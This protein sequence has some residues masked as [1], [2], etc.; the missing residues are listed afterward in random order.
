MTDPG[1]TNPVNQADPDATATTG[2]TATLT[3]FAS[4][5]E[6]AGRSTMDVPL[7]DGD[8]YRDVLRRSAADNDRLGRIV[9]GSA[10]FAAGELVRDLD[11]PAE[12]TELDVL[13]P[14]AGG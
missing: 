7:R 6:A 10:V 2:R 13:P 4:A 1:T 5:A 14:F 12:V 9:D 8:T 11:R 3:F